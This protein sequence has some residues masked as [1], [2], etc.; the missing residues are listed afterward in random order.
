M[1]SVQLPAIEIPEMETGNLLPLLHQVRHALELLLERGETTT[2]D[3]R[4]LPLAPGEEQRLEAA[5]G[6]G[7]IEVTLHALGHSTLHETRFSGVWHITHYNAEGEVL[8]KFLEV[9]RVPALLEARQEEM[10][11]AL[12]ALQEQLDSSGESPS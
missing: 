1:N 10:Q 12:A 3:L 7:E 9:A 5:L 4:A 11:A 8:G 6:Q 2:I